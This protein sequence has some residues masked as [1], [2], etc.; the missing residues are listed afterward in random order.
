MQCALDSSLTPTWITVTFWLFV[1]FG[2]LGTLGFIGFRWKDGLWGSLLMSFNLLFATLITVNYYEPLGKML[3]GALPIGLFYWDSLVFI[4]LLMITFAI[5]NMIT[6]KL[7]RVI[8]MF[9]KPVEYVAMP[10]LLLGVWVFL[11]GNLT[12]YLTQITSTA[13]KP[14]AGWYDIDKPGIPPDSA[15]RGI[16]KHA[17]TGSLSTLGDPT[18]FDP[19]NDFLL[20]HYSRRCA[21]LDELWRTGNSRF[22]GN[23][24]FLD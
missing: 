6:N 11:F 9:P 21:L 17:S 18:E 24:E 3:A 2:F 16:M 13:P 4:I 5:F 22:S 7:S 1:F 10:L 8:V 23:A 14:L 15:L 12:L 20:R 19:D